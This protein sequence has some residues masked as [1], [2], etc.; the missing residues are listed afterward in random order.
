[1]K[2]IY[3][4]DNKYNRSFIGLMEQC[5][6]GE[7]CKTDEAARK[8]YI[9]KLKNYHMENEITGLNGKIENYTRLT[10]ILLFTSGVSILVLIAALIK[11]YTDI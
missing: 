10:S 11:I 8:L 9:A 3:K 7:W 6:T 2:D 5:D 4:I 1:M